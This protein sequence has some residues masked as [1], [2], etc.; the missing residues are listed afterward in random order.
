MNGKPTVFLCLAAT[1]LV[2]AGCATDSGTRQFKP[3]PV[4]RVRSTNLKPVSPKTAT[5]LLRAAQ[6]QFETANTAQ[7]EGDREAALRHYT[8]MLELLAEANLDPGVF[9]NLRREFGRILDTT[10]YHASLFDR[11]RP[12]R[13]TEEDFEER[14]VGDLLIEFPLHQRVFEEIEEIKTAYAQNFQAGLDRSYKYMPYIR[15]Q[16]AKAGLPTDLAWLAMIESQFSPKVISRAGAG[17]MWQ[18]MR[19]TARRYNLRID[20]YVDERFNWQRSTHAAAVYLRDLFDMFGG[21]W[22]LA[23]SAYN[24]GEG[25][26]ERVIAAAG[27]ERDLWKLMESPGASRRMQEETKKFY[28]K[29]LASIIAARDPERFGFKSNPQPPEE[30]VLVPIKGSYSLATLEKACGLA[31]GTLRQLNPDLIRGVT[32]P[33]G[34]HQL[35]V[36]RNASGKAA[37]AVSK[38]PQINPEPVYASSGV[39]VVKRGETISGIAK[40]YKVSSSAIMKANGLRSPRHL[41]IGK[42]LV[43]PGLSTAGA[44]TTVTV[45]GKGKVYT[46]MPG[47]TLSEIAKAQKVPIEQLKALNNIGRDSKIRAGQKLVISPSAGASEPVESKEE[48]SEEIYIVRAGEYPAKIART[49]GVKLEDFLRWNGL[50]MR[51]KIDIDDKLVIRKPNGSQSGKPAGQATPTQ[52]ADSPPHGAETI[53]HKVAKGESASVI[54]NIYGVRTSDFLKW[55]GLSTRTVLK[56]GDEYV[57]HITDKDA[58]EPQAEPEKAPEP[59]EPKKTIHKVSRGQNPTTIARRYGVKVSDLYKWN[60]WDKDE[61]LQIGQE[62]VIYK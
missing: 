49:H 39:H 60:A 35:T 29:L 41:Q 13:W 22:P 18:F 54:A 53:T 27:G 56:I 48:L 9:Y 12:T 4:A 50:N 33:V 14:V 52:T 61:V 1:V 31:D 17:G 55:N 7:E 15:V 34:E 24:M 28:A 30:T 62:V 38:L 20:S 2:M 45:P 21:S 23:V 32:P 57:L 59:D 19:S 25:G 37:A 5:Q 40:R 11:K 47:D 43:I 26:L 44:G 8:R 51:S 58:D 46:V 16:L 36:P 6:E 10:E 42:N 3:L